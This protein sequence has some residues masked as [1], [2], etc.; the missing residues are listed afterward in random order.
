MSTCNDIEAIVFAPFSNDQLKEFHLHFLHFCF[1]FHYFFYGLLFL[2]QSCPLLLFSFPS[3]PVLVL[4][5][6]IPCRHSMAAKH[7]DTPKIVGDGKDIVCFFT[8]RICGTRVWL[9]ISFHFP[10]FL[11]SFCTLSAS[12]L[13]AAQP[14]KSVGEI[15]ED[16]LGKQA[17]RKLV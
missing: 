16:G 13:S 10:I 4:V 17:G 2:S 14:A 12:A 6:H 8:G 11:S 5:V 9:F 1:C 7:S 3:H 15:I